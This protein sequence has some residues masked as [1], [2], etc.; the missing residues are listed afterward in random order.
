MLVIFPTN[1]P[2]FGEKQKIFFQ[3]FPITF[4]YKYIKQISY[5]TYSYISL[6]TIHTILVHYISLIYMKTSPAQDRINIYDFYLKNETNEPFK[7]KVEIAKCNEAFLMK[8]GKKTMPFASPLFSLPIQNIMRHQY[9]KHIE[10]KGIPG[11]FLKP[12]FQK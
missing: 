9:Y 6:Q 8:F 4:R 12:T 2:I 3:F 11:F 1:I 10:Q 5:N 7:V